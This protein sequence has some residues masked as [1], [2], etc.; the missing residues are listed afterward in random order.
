MDFSEKQHALRYTALPWHP[1]RLVPGPLWIPKS[2][3]A[4]VPYT[5]WHGFAYNL[6][7][8]SCRL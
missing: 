6:S 7:T 2:M 1:E 3:D 4:Q 8:C 5:E